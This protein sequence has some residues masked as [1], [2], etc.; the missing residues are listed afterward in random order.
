MFALSR[1]IRLLFSLS[2]YLNHLY[3]HRLLSSL[4]IASLLT[5]A[6]M[7]ARASTIVVPVGGD[8]QAAINAAACGDDIALQA[9]ASFSGNFVLKYKGPCSGSDADYIT[10]R[11]SNL[12]GLPAA[13]TIIT[14]SYAPAMAK[15]VANSFA[16]ALEAEANA[17]HYKLIGLE[18]TNIG[19]S[20][21]TQELVVLGGRSSGGRIPFPQHPHHLT[22][23]RSWIHEATND[24]TTPNSVTTTAIRGFNLDATDIRIT[25]CR[26]A[27]F[28]TYQPTPQGLE[29]SNAILFPTSAL[30]VTV[31][32]TYLEAWFVPLFFGGS[33]GSSPNTA[34]VSNATPTRARLSSVSNLSVGDLIAFKVA[35][36]H[37]PAGA[38]CSNCSVA[39]Q[40]AKVSAIN[41]NVVDYAGQSN[42]GGTGP[43][44][45]PLLQ[46]PESPGLAQWNGYTNQDITI[47]RCQ[48]VSNFNSTEYVW[49]H[50]GGTPTTLPRSQQTST[51]NAPKGNIEIK[52][53]RNLTIDGNTFEGWHSGIVLTSRNQG[54]T[55]TSGGFP[56]ASVENLRITNNWWKRSPNWNRIYS[57]IIGGP[58]LE[59]NEYTSK[60]GGP[61]LISNNL[62]E[63]GANELLAA[64]AGADN[65]TVVHN[66]YPG[67]SVSPGGSAINAIGNNQSFVVKDNILPNNEYGLQNCQYAGSCWPNKVQTNNVIIDNRSADGKIG[68][69]PLNYPNNF[70]TQGVIWVD[71]VNTNYRLGSSSPYK[72]KGSDGKDPGVDMDALLLALSSSSLPSPTPTPTPTPTV[73]PSPS[74]S[75]TPTVSPTPLPTPT[76]T[77]GNN[78]TSMTSVLRAKDH[79]TLLAGRMEA[80][81]LSSLRHHAVS[82]RF[83]GL[84]TP[85]A[86]AS[87]LDALTNDI[88]LAHEDFLR[89]R[90]LF[91]VGAGSIET[92]LSAALLFSRA[93]AAMA[94][95]IGDS[96]S[97]AMHLDRIVSHLTITE[98]LMLY[99]SISAMTAD[100]ANAARARMD[101]VIGYGTVGYDDQGA[102]AIAPASLSLVFNSVAQ[103]F[104]LQSVFASPPQAMSATYE[105][106]GVSVTV[107]G[108]AAQLVYVS[109][110]RLAFV[111]PPDATMGSAE[112]IIA[113]QDGYLARGVAIISRNVFHLLTS[114]DGT[115]D[116][117][118]MNLA[119]PTNGFE[120]V[121]AENL[122]PDKRTRVALFTVG[123][124]GCAVNSDTTND[125]TMAGG[126][127]ANFAES[128]AVEARQSNGRV[129]S[130]PVEF[131]G[132]QAGMIGL[133][134]VNLRLSEELRGAGVV[135]LT[136]IIAGQRSNSAR[137]LIH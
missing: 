69:G 78:T 109:P 1:C 122:G 37:Q 8:L 28:R 43:G 56:W 110:T 12:A 72:G 16:P 98:D 130:V 105:L 79:A 15:L 46:S 39:F 34:T 112:L 83:G 27:G 30:R 19:G 94:L 118:A 97:V 106:G 35:N 53:A 129:I 101:L 58:M 42:Y 73:S 4:S 100:R 38:T 44:G 137:F 5:L 76:P 24:T 17:H 115:G 21:V 29:A 135:E 133:D 63:S 64:F 52:M 74:P 95:K 127:I 126:S 125:I 104:G 59:D 61:V 51:G 36:G 96:A 114:A 123:I 107:G 41:G 6:G 66:T 86:L 49:T 90:D 40:V 62:F 70:V 103:P 45:N 32:N 10:I 88:V 121:T 108:Q 89:E 113:S 117:I 134:Q 55:Q 26:I 7:S 14:P 77:P 80:P 99:G 120:V 119:T 92:Q 33:G 54:D 50:T 60:R 131:A 22:F 3:L 91:G 48:F 102:G 85:A 18:I 20:I 11:T 111:V 23:D 71:P 57:I 87:D 13:G 25:E 84:L 81:A 116:A 124:S 9:G 75:A 67:S 132:A 128:V 93:N 136:L 82:F 68:D 31:S 65:V 47:Q 2:S